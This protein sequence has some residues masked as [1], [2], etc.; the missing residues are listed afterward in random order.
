M[1]LT[2]TLFGIFTSLDL[3]E[4]EFSLLTEL[5][6]P[7]GATE[8][9]LRTALARMTGKN[10]LISE[11]RERKAVYSLS[12]R[13]ARV[14]GNIAAAFSPRDAGGWT[15]DYWS[16]GFT[17][18]DKEKGLRYRVR[19]KLSAYRFGGWLPGL[20]IR[21]VIPAEP[22]YNGLRELEETSSCRLMRLCP[23][24]PLSEPE[25]RRIWKLVETSRRLRGA[26]QRIERELTG[27][28]TLSP[29][30][31]FVRRY[32]VGNEAVS[33]L[34][35]DPLLPEAMTR[36]NWPGDRLRQIFALWDREVAERAHPF[37]FPLTGKRRNQ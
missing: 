9:A 7:F 20:W 33:A 36:D 3:K 4:A 26:L 24:T 15:G 14:G 27:L 30:E 23:E 37:Y 5:T 13:G 35:E 16:A 8:T 25:I 32:E 31:A 2:E 1:N 29:R 34:A 10:L 19:K 18:P 22:P 6:A 21:P 11:R 17:L 12:G 28:Q